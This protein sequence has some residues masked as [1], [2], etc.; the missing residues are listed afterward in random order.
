MVDPPSACSSL[1]ST[2]AGSDLNV[3]LKLTDWIWFLP[4][5]GTIVARTMPALVGSSPVTLDPGADRG[6]SFFWVRR[7]NYISTPPRRSRKGDV[8]VRGAP[9]G[10]RTPGAG[11]CRSS[12]AARG[13]R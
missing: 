4:A 6:A 3:P 12:P 5:P 10:I 7:L 13:A 9:E 8:N 2:P 11:D 1:A